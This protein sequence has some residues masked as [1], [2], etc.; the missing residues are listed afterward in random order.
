MPQYCKQ[1]RSRLKIFWHSIYPLFS[2]YPFIFSNLLSEAEIE[3]AK[4][5]D[6]A[7]ARELEFKLK[8]LQL[9]IEQR[10]TVSHLLNTLEMT[11]RTKEYLG[12][13]S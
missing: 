2:I 4:L 9:E 6:A 5:N 13:E 7:A 11:D 12:S 1:K 10:T 3:K 8:Q